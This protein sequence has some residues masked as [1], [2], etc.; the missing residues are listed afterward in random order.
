MQKGSVF[1]GDNEYVTFNAVAPSENRYRYKLTPTNPDNFDFDAKLFTRNF[2]G[3]SDDR[4]VDIGYVRLSGE[5]ISIDGGQTE[6]IFLANTS[7]DDGIVVYAT[8]TDGDGSIHYYEV[9][10][11]ELNDTSSVYSFDGVKNSKCF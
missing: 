8:I 4:L 5:V 2:T 7:T 6:R 3:N 1:D 10:A 11:V 9:Y